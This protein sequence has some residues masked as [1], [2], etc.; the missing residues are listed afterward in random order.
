V[1]SPYYAWARRRGRGDPLDHCALNVALYGERGNHWAMTE[2]GRAK[3]SRSA[4]SLAIGPSMLTWDGDVL[5]IRID[6]I[7]APIPSLVRGVVRV[8]PKAITGRAFSLDRAGRHRWEPIAPSAHVAVKMEQPA[9]RWRGEG[10]VDSNSGGEPIEEAFR[11]WHWSRASLRRGT[12]VLYDVADRGGGER[13]LALEFGPGGD[14]EE[15]DLPSKATLPPTR[16]KIARVT[17]AD[18]PQ[19]VV[20][21][22]TLESSPFYARSLLSTRLLG[23]SAL[24]MHESLSLDRFRSRWVQAM[25]PFRMPR[26]S[27]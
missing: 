26:G 20:V 24:A 5:T 9:V 1:F 13:P 14:V 27:W 19:S 22:K 21:L 17:R 2:R 12:A 7:T 25:L 8:Y 6:E 16:W 15:I 3:V 4:S 18:E 23:Q 11:H 10:Y